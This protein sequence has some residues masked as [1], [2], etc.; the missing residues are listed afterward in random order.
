[1]CVVSVEDH[2]LRGAV[3]LLITVTKP[4]KY[5]VSCA[6]TATELLVGSV[7]HQSF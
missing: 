3:L 1:M 2:R 4:G 6:I 7:T 5:V